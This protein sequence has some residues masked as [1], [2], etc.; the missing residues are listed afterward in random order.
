MSAGGTGAGIRTRAS[1]VAEWRV[2]G[3]AIARAVARSTIE[4]DLLEWPTQDGRIR[5]LREL[6]RAHGAQ[7]AVAL[8]DLERPETLRTLQMMVAPPSAPWLVVTGS[9]PGPRWG[10]VIESGA[11]AVLPTS[12]PIGALLR[13]IQAAAAGRSAM[14]ED[15]RRQVVQNWRGATDEQRWALLRI[16]RLT[17]RENATIRMLYCGMSVREIA[18]ASGVQESTV[19]SQVKRLRAKLEVE[20]QLAAVAVYKRAL[21]LAPSHSTDK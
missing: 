19:R 17:P 12:T 14:P 4:P 18:L 6:V 8:C 20:S 15:L 7:V 2:E 21:E 9:P 3:E 10:I 13:A 1:I 16:E 11:V 5:E